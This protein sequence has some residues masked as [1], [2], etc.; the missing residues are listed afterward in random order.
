MNTSVYIICIQQDW[1]FIISAVVQYKREM[2][3]FLM[4]ALSGR[5]NDS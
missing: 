2:L 4:Q 5:L 1:Y 3:M